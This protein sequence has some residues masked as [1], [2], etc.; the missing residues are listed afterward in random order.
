MH[1]H[2]TLLQ[3]DQEVKLLHEYTHQSG[4]SL[5]MIYSV[6]TTDDLREIKPA[7]K[8]VV[9]PGCSSGKGV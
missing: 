3:E 6:Q 8:C 9:P 7:A 2:L 5:H 4:Y 1:P